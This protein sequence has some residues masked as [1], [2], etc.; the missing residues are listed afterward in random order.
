MI[1]K[2]QPEE[3]KIRLETGKSLKREGV[4]GRDKKLKDLRR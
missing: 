3:S 1:F 2:T 4:G